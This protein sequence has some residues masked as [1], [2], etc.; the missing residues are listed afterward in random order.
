MGGCGDGDEGGDEHDIGFDA[1]VMD[2]EEDLVH[3]TRGTLVLI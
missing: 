3:Y 1:A 2:V